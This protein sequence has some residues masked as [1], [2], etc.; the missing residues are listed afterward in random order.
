MRPT[1][2]LRLYLSVLVT[3]RYRSSYL[4]LLMDGVYVYV[5]VDALETRSGRGPRRI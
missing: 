4:L 3:G 5:E 1:L 2:D